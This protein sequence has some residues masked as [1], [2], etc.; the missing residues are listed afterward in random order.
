MVRVLVLF[1]LLLQTSAA[2]ALVSKVPLQRFTSSGTFELRC[3][4]GGQNLSFPIPARWDV[5]KASLSLQYMVSNNMIGELSQM[6]VKL[7]GDPISKLKLNPQAPS[8]NADIMMPLAL[9]EVGY[10]DL[11]FQV[12]Q[13]YQTNQCEQPCAPDLWTNIS[14]KES[15]IQIEYELKP[16]P[17]RLGEA[18][19]MMFDPKQFPQASVNLITDV[20]SPESLTMAGVVASGIARHFDYR[21]VQFSHSSEV[22]PGVDNVLV[23]TTQFA[24]GILERYRLS[25]TAGQGGLIKIFQLPTLLGGS[26]RHHGLVVVSGDDDLALKVAAK[27]FANM[28]LPYPGTDELRAFSFSMPD[29]SMYGGRRVLASDKVYDFGALGMSSYSFQGQTGRPGKRG[30]GVNSSGLNFRL[31]PD[32]LIKQNQYA[33][34][35]LNFAYGAGMRNDSTVTITVNDQQVRDLHLDRAGG[36]YVEGYKVDLPT[37]LFKPGA[38]TITFRPYINTQRQV[39]D[40]A[41]TDGLF[42]TI[43]DNSTLFF[44]PMPHF[45]EMPKLELFALNGFP[46]TRWPDGFETLV[47][48]PKPDAASIDTAMNLI[49]MITQRNGFPLFGTQ[50]TLTEPQA[51]DGETLVIGTA[52]N[53]PKSLIDRAPMQVE[54]IGNVPY[55]V[56][57]SWDSETSISLSKQISGLGAANGLLMQFESA[58]KRGRSVVVA[59]AHT[60]PDLLALGD[61]LLSPGIISR[62]A[63]DLSIIRLNVPEYDLINLSVGSKYSTG[64]TE[65]TSVIDALLYRS[66]YLLYGLLALVL[67]AL[68]L[69]FYKVLQRIRAK[70]S[71]S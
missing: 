70:R 62:V 42:V 2:Q 52:A 30:F 21:K 5:R 12:A 57:R 27:T 36:N 3:V 13:H 58:Y 33:K 63:G 19:E 69:I 61:A 59:T 9:L 55:P 49:G 22:R 37:F 18:F 29:I 11:S 64:N 32:F 1:F 54:G 67:I 7:N 38:N 20:S 53:I 47:Y 34:L 39:C 10:N 44:P 50:I 4:S 17:L 46:F 14:L 71:T 16:I 48:L 23:G 45:V 41:I 24:N 28:S 6:V 15:Y 43:F 60:E 40:V 68:C 56:N 35:T 65:N 51:W 31:P 26:Y 8:A 66:P 25:S